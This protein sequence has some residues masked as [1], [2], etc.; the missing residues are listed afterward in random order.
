VAGDRAFRNVAALREAVRDATY[1]LDYAPK[2][3]RIALVEGTWKRFTAPDGS[4]VQHEDFERFV[5]AQPYEGL[6]VTVDAMR[7]IISP[8][9]ELGAMFEKA[10]AGKAV[11]RPRDYRS[12]VQQVLFVPSSARMQLDLDRLQHTSR[13]IYARVMRGDISLYEGMIEAGLRD[14]TLTVRPADL[15][16]T[17][18]ALRNRLSPSQLTQ[19][20]KLL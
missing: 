11:A 2:F 17:A 8:N 1:G 6:G 12:A 15:D 20:K 14:R 16:S 3:L 10:L 4:L 19:L 13:A 18:R 5:V 7:R 9:K